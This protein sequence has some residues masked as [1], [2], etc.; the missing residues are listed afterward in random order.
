MVQN[1]GYKLYPSDF[2]SDTTQYRLSF[3]VRSPDVIQGKWKL[4]IKKGEEEDFLS[5]FSEE[6]ASPDWRN[7]TVAVSL[8]IADSFLSADWVELLFEGSPATADFS[9]D[10]ISLGDGDDLTWQDEAN[11][12]IEKLRKRRVELNFLDIEALGLTIEVEQTS[13]LFP[14]GQA[15]DSDLIASCYD[16]NQDDNYCN[17]VRNNFNMI[18]DTYRLHR[19]GKPSIAEMVLRLTVMT[20]D[21][22][23]YSLEVKYSN[24]LELIL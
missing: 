10:N 6:I 23:L 16:T 18:T 20:T 4:H 9:L 22:S 2:S 12:R 15:V 8:D 19:L 13:H 5:L 21:Y 3:S 11:E 1:I 7:Y 14:F 17:Y 24:E